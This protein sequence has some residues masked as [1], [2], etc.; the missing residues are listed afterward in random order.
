MKNMVAHAS[1]TDVSEGEAAARSGNGFATKAWLRALALTAPIASHP[2]RTFP[3]VIEELAETVGEAPALLSDRE[4]LTYRALAERSNRYAR[5]ALEEGLV[6]G[7]RRLPLDA[8]PAR[9]HGH[10]ARHNP[11][12]RCRVTP[13]HQSGRALAR[14][15]HQ[16]RRAQA[17][18][19]GG[20]LIDPLI[21]ALPDLSDAVRIWAHGAG[22]TTSRASIA[23]SSDTRAKR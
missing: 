14:P 7:R 21:A 1:P 10:L 20:G 9:I 16:S 5:W 12:R 22:L 15:L 17:H 11:R 3:T 23:P 18:R 6:E 13:Q 19:R 4:C 2:H 8:E